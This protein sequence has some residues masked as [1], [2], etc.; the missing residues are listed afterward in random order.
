MDTSFLRMLAT[1]V[2]LLTAIFVGA[3]LGALYLVIE[4]LPD[5]FTEKTTIIMG[6]TTAIATG[7]TVAVS[8]VAGAFVAMSTSRRNI[9]AAEAQGNTPPE[10]K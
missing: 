10:N 1:Y 3:V 8:A 7:V 4:F 5:T 9:S 2:V 6:L